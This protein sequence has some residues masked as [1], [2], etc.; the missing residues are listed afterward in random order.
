MMVLN[1]EKI[2]FYIIDYNKLPIEVKE[3]MPKKDGSIC[4][5]FLLPNWRKNRFDLVRKPTGYLES[6][7]GSILQA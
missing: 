5:K 2:N 4:M 3:R 7:Y 1:F 6:S